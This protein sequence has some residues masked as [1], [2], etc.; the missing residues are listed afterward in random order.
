[1]RMSPWLRSGRPRPEAT[2]RLFLFHHAGG[3]ASAFHGWGD[4]APAE[5]ETVAVQLPGREN[6]FSEPLITAMDPIVRAVA[7][8]L[9]PFVDEPF[10]LF[11][12]SMG[13]RVAYAVS[14][15]LADRGRPVPSALVVSA[16]RAPHHPS[17]RPNLHDLPDDVFIDELVRIGGIPD[18][19]R[20]SGE[21]MEMMARIARADFSVLETWS[22]PAGRR[23]PAPI[24]ALGGED[25]GS[26]PRAALQSWADLADG[27]FRVRLFP[28]G[29]FY[30]R[31]HARAVVAEASSALFRGLN[32]RTA[33][34]A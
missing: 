15:E 4:L 18:A 13:A 11:G 5:V 33:A 1:M 23:S 8:A 32:R 3:A 17:A 34:R 12:H 7:D 26:A 25:D 29:H 14:V 16:S 6:R 19:I 31:D 27:D 20:R 24:V 30:I 28:G 21:M 9:D 10:A 2:A 22:P